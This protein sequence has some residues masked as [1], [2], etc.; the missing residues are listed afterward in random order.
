[1]PENNG[2]SFT[3]PPISIPSNVLWLVLL[4][5]LGGPMVSNW[6]QQQLGLGPKAELPPA[7][8]EEISQASKETEANALVTV[9]RFGHINTLM[10]EL[11]DEVQNLRLD[12]DVLTRQRDLDSQEHR[13]ALTNIQ[14][15]VDRLSKEL[16]VENK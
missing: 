11:R 16:G 2:K 15:K 4:A 6:A 5:S 12:L 3:L 10:R 1:M 8:V 14:R 13:N 9:T 7:V